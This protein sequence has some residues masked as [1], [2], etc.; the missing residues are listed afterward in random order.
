MNSKI[1]ALLI[2]CLVLVT[3]TFVTGCKA[4]ETPYEINDADNYTVSVKY[5]ANGGIFTTNTS[6]IVDSFNISEIAEEGSDVAKIALISPDNALRGNDAF[7]AIKNGYFLAGWYTDRSETTD[8]EGNKAYI[9]SGKWNFEENTLDVDT[10]KSYTSAEPVLTLYAAWVPMFKIDFYSLGTGEFID[11]YSFNPTT[12]TEFNIPDWDM[13]TGM[14][15]MYNF[16]TVSG[17]TFNGAYL[18]AEGTQKLDGETFTHIG[19]VDYISGVAENPA[20]NVYVD[21]T[22]GEWYHIYNAEQFLENASVNGSYEIHAD[23][24]FEGEIWPTSLM[25]GNFSGKIIGNGH[26]MKNIELTQTNNSKVNAGLFG[27]LT[28]TSSISDIT[29]ENVTFTVKAGT[30]V[31]G[32]SYGILA[33]TLSPKAALTNVAVKGGTMQIDSSCYFGVDDY[34]IGLICGMGDHSVVVAENLS[35]VAVGDAPENV[36]I[37]V[38]GNDVTLN[39]K[40]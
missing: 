9:Y 7:T 26:T 3:L 17:Y 20:M 29:F 12:V 14:I 23:L 38:N 25:Y 19:S 36:E 11:S 24:D 34:S 31:V 4:E 8:S 35:C 6:V 16:P 39:F 22:E 37:T 28:D 13:E 40:A 1:R 2:A 5:D 18:D 27:Y 10:S 30:R 15:E 33:G 21:L 32:T